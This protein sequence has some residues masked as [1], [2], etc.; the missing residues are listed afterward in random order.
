MYFC[1]QIKDKEKKGIERNN[2]YLYKI[3]Y[4]IFIYLKKRGGEV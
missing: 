2:I 1:D 3:F 4:I